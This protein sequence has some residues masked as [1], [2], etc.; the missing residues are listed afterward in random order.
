MSLQ[1]IDRNIL[2]QLFAE[3]PIQHG[4]FFDDGRRWCGICM[5]PKLICEPSENDFWQEKT[6]SDCTCLWPEYV[7]MVVHDLM[8]DDDLPDD[9][10]EITIN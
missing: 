4:Q 6:C 8:S 2:A 7:H 10:D 9:F 5:H 1:L 3:E